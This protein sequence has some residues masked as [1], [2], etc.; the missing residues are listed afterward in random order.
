MTVL[1]CMFLQA[2]GNCIQVAWLRAYMHA[3]QAYSRQLVG[4]SLLLRRQLAGTLQGAF[5]EWKVVAAQ[6]A[7]WHRVSD[8]L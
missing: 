4:A 6:L 2:F 3:W 5:H 7:Y 8:H 1:L